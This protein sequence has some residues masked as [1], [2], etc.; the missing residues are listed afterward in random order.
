MTM[1]FQEELDRD[2]GANDTEWLI[3][4]IQRELDCDQSDFIIKD[5][6]LGETTGQHVH[7]VMRP[8]DNM[9]IL[10]PMMAVTHK[11]LHDSTVSQAD[12]DHSCTHAGWILA[13][14][15]M[16]WMKLYLDKISYHY[17]INSHRWTRG[18]A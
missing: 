10:L 14:I 16:S 15:S 13:Y 17:H 9:F 7:I 8:L 5:T 6:F 1:D 4:I 18:V 2:F 11:E 12:T 3:G